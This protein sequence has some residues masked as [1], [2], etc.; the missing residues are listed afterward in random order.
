MKRG[1]VGLLGLG[2]TVILVGCS[3]AGP[4]LPEVTPTLPDLKVA[5]A[6]GEP[7]ALGALPDGGPVWP[8]GMNNKGQIVGMAR[9]AAGDNRAV[10][11]QNGQATEL[12]T[13]DGYGFWDQAQEINDKGQAVGILIPEGGGRAEFLPV[14]WESPESAPTPLQLLPGTTG[15]AARGIN[16]DGEIAGE[17]TGGTRRAVIWH[18]ATSAPIALPLLPGCSGSLAMENNNKGMVVGMAICETEPSPRAVLWEDDQVTELAVLSGSP[19]SLA[20]YVN[21]AGQM[22]GWNYFSEPYYPPKPGDHPVLWETPTQI[23]DLGTLTTPGSGGGMSINKHGQI[24]LELDWHAVVWEDGQM[25][26]LGEGRAVAINDKGQVVGHTVDLGSVLW[27]G[28]K[29]VKT[30]E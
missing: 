23:V 12:A 4:T 29:Y 18:D 9:N 30:K 11:W 5:P 28:K 7:I 10:L 20:Y 2:L 8:Y 27:P 17:S 21:D 19:R 22:V 24:A 1:L 3:D 6:F 16:E 14:I 26:D 15:G 13:L 25:T